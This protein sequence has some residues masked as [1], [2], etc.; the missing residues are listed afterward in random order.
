MRPAMLKQYVESAARARWALPVMLLVAVLAMAVNEVT[1]QHAHHT[2]TRGITLTD[3]RINAARMVQELTDAELAVSSY[4]IG[5]QDERLVRWQRAREN[6][7]TV[8]ALAIQLSTQVEPGVA[9]RLEA[10]VSSLHSRMDTL[11]QWMA[12]AR[13]G[14]REEALALASTG[15][16]GQPLAALRLEFDG[17]LDQASGAQQAARVSLYDAMMITRVAVHALVVLSVLALL[18]FVRQLRARDEERGEERDRLETKIRERTFELHA[19]ATS[20]VT[21]REDE[22]ARL[23]RELHDE[24]G[25]LLTAM[26]LEFA[27]LKRTAALPEGALA[28]VQ[29]IEARLNDGIALKR[30]IIENLRPSSL[31]QLGLRAALQLLCDDVAQ[32]AGLDVQTALEDVSLCRDAELALYRLV[33][34][35]LTNTVKYAKATQVHVLLA[36]VGGMAVLQVQDDGQGFDPR[37]ARPGHHG[38][39]G[40]RIRMESHAGSLLIDSAPGRG[41][42]IRAELPQPHTAA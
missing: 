28:R 42:R 19:L 41:T 13:Q 17:I 8:K 1:F 3:A 31:D 38:L 14:R 4:L 40:M 33:Q 7:A 18:L 6:L 30:R 36:A 11:E 20:M 23:A 22:R 24:M 26:K 35:S 16:P 15:V 5:M 2:L 29:G 37:V 12:L 9:Q 27:R 10:L 25:G 39:A 34:E 32:N 21:A